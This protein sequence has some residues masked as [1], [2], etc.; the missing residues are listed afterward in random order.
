MA[1]S[2]RTTSASNTPSVSNGESSKAAELRAFNLAK[3]LTVI[4]EDKSTDDEEWQENELDFWSTSIFCY[5]LGSNPPSNVLGGYVR[6]I[7]KNLTIDKVAFQPNGVC[8]VRFK[9]SEDKIKALQSGPLFFD[10]KPFIVKDWA[11]DSKLEK[12]KPKS[13]HILIR[14]YNLSFK[15]WGNALPKLAGLVG[16]PVQCDRATKEREFLEYARYMVEVQ[17]GQPLP[18]AIDFLDENGVLR[19]QRVHYE[20]KPAVCA[21]CHGIGHE[22]GSCK[23]EPSKPAPKKVNMVWKPKVVAPMVAKPV[24]PSQGRTEEVLPVLN[25]AS[26]VTPMPF[27]GSMTNTVTPAAGV[28]HKIAKRG[29]GGVQSGPS[30][31][32]VLS[33]SIRRNLL[34]SLSKGKTTLHFNGFF[35]LIETRVKSSNINKVQDGLGTKWKFLVNNDVIEGGRIWILWDPSLFTVNVISKE[36]QLMHLQVTYLPN[37]FSWT[38]SMIYGSNKDADRSSLWSSLKSLAASVHGPWLVMGDFNNVL[39]SDERIGAKV[40]DAETKEFQGCVDHCGLYDLVVQGAYYTWNNKQDGDARVFSRIDRV[41]ANDQWI[42]H[43]PAGTVNFLP[44]GLFDHSPSIISLWEDEEKHKSSF[45]YFMMWSKDGNFKETVQGIWNQQIRGCLMFQVAKKLKMLKGPLKKLNREGFGDIINTTEVARLVLEK[46]QSQLHLDPHNSLLQMEERAAAQSFKQ[47]QDAKFS[48][49]GQKAKVA[50]MTCNDENTHYFHSSIKARRAQNKVLKILDMNGNP[51]SDNGSIEMAFIEYY[52]K[53][54]GSSE[55][56]TRVNCGV[57][58]R[59]KCVSDFQSDSMV[60]EVTKEE[61]R[62][63]LFSI[64][65]EKAP[66]PDGY[67]SSFFKDAFDIIGDDVMG[68]VLEFFSHDQLLQQINSTM[69]TLVPKK[70]LPISVMD[71][72]PIAC[73]NVVYKCI[74]KIICGRLNDVLADIISLNQSAFLKNRDIVDNILICQ[75]LVRLYKRRTCSPRVMMKIDLRK[76]YDSIEWAFVEDMLYALQFP[77]RMIGWIMQCVST[78]SYTLS[79]NGNQFGYFKGKRGLRQGDPIS[80]LLFTLCL[81]YFTRI[82]DLVTVTQNFRFHPMCKALK[83]CHLAFADDLLIFC[84]GDSDS[85]TVIM[86]ALT[87]FS[88]ASGLHINKDKSDIFVN[89]I[90]GVA[91]DN[92]LHISGF[93]KGALPF[94]YLGINI[95]HKRLTKIHSYWARVFLLPKAIIHKVESICRAYLWSGSDEHHKGGLGIIN[96]YHW[97]IATL[98]KYIWWVANKKDSL[99][100]RWVYHLY[101]KQ[102][103]WWQ[104]SP[105]LQTSWTWRQLCK[106]KDL[107]APGFAQWLQVPYSISLVYSW[108]SGSQVTVPWIPYVWNRL[109]LPKVNFINWLFIQGRLLTK[110]RLAKFGVINDGI[111]FL[112]GTMQETSLHLFF[113]CPFSLRCLHLLQT[114]L[115]FFWTVDVIA[116]SLNWREKSLLRKKIILAAIASLV[117]YIWEGRNK[118]RLGDWVARPEAVRERIHATLRGRLHMLQMEK[119]P[120]RDIEWVKNVILC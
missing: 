84:R 4:S 82:L 34:N 76:A 30:F 1:R 116:N 13:V 18:D 10:S 69:I 70:E 57:V 24:T 41:L 9:N 66:G 92:I 100:V 25:P 105:S 104:Y 61:V 86:R 71:F 68:A 15:Y 95:S 5:V 113:E 27:Q 32:D 103:D 16:S 62:A 114:R 98:G 60:A 46:K 119:V 44:E 111:C 28:I 23:K 58:R 110:D 49:L 80:P 35:G 43:G 102:H 52:Q 12:E 14:F 48:F 101:I 120:S 55:S 89:G 51:C 75:D 17:V 117:Y 106:V 108:L 112:C 74:S 36:W 11:P 29:E 59:G 64:P 97:N 83:L 8:L 72:R 88:N 47:L 37:G 79:L 85:V 109:A 91:E 6:R 96:C 54:L 65:N 26:V 115:G 63:A 67:S 19:T 22:T 50:W 107:L 87:T 33:F 2:R 118:C 90:H 20:W 31:M 99:W 42:L 78:P 77:R 94:K 3:E 53:L 38:C 73:C 39:Y 56:V 40:T 21:T 45:K 7:W 93:K 81:E